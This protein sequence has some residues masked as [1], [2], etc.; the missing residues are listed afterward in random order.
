MPGMCVHP[1]TYTQ[2]GKKKSSGLHPGIKGG[3]Q[4]SDK[5][6]ALQIK[7]DENAP[8]FSQN[9]FSVNAVWVGALVLAEGWGGQQPRKV[10][11]VFMTRMLF[12]TLDSLPSRKPYWRY[13]SLVSIS[14]GWS[15]AIGF[16][17]LMNTMNHACLLPWASARQCQT[18]GFPVKGAGFNPPPIPSPPSRTAFDSLCLLIL[19]S[20]VTMNR[21]LLAYSK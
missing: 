11:T 18:W 1:P 2:H 15:Q 16:V 8:L 6:G 9:R 5:S 21:F 12:L 20:F 14:A 19:S 4:Q 7:F 10:I 17:S 13:F 3:G